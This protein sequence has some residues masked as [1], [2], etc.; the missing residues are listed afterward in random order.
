MPRNY[1]RKQALPLKGRPPNNDSAEL[2]VI[3][4]LLGQG[5][6]LN[7]AIAALAVGLAVRK[8][9]MPKSAKECLS[10]AYRATER[11]KRE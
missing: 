9:I 11:M 7:S 8:N 1:Q 2:N 3:D 4:I 6:D 5:W 10:Q